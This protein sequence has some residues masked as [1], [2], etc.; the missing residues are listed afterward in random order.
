MD[1]TIRHEDDLVIEL[2]KAIYNRFPAPKSYYRLFP[3][4]GLLC[5]RFWEFRY[6]GILK[7]FDT[8]FQPK[9]KYSPS[10]HSIFV[11]S[12]I[13]K[14]KLGRIEDAIG[15]HKSNL[16]EAHT[17]PLPL[18]H[19]NKSILFINIGIY[20]KPPSLIQDLSDSCE[21]PEPDAGE[22]QFDRC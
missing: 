1:V 8:I 13:G 2:K 11:N 14:D 22:L 7:G 15:F 12:S 19:R 18:D 10:L 4:G 3:F 21:S 16:Y 6:G 9:F 20:L 17:N 5:Q